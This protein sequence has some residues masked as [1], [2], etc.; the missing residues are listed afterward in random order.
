LYEENPTQYQADI[1]R[2]HRWIRGDWQ[3]GAWMLP[4]VTGNDGRLTKNTLS[5]LSRWKIFDNL[6]RSLLPLSL[7]LLLLVGWFLLPLPWLWTLTVTVT[8][9]LPVMAAAGWRLA[10]KPI[11]LTLK[12]HLTEI[13]ISVRD[14]LIRFMFGIA[15]LPYEAF[16]YTD[17]IIRTNW[18]MIVSGKKLLE[19]TPSAGASQKV[20]TDMGAVFQ[21]MWMMPLL[22]LICMVSLAYKNT[23]VLFVAAPMLILWFIAPALSWRLSRPEA[24][25]SQWLPEEQ[26]LFLHKSARKTWSFFEQFVTESENWLPPD[27]FQQQPVAIIAHR[28]SPTNLGLALLANLTAYDFGYIGGGELV[29]RCKNALESMLKLERYQGHFYNWY[30]TLTLLPLL[31][32]YVSTVDSGNLVGHLLTLRQGLLAL[33]AQPLF[34]QK[35]YEGLKTTT[36]IIQELSTGNQAEITEKILTVLEN[37]ANGRPQTDARNPEAAQPG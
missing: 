22:S 23:E 2:H 25:E 24:E 1:K 12:A 37:A 31:P 32:R 9:L 17:A 36:R 5:A 28:T 6:R 4:F 35:I 33:P 20:G 8:I 26:T 3:I 16:K 7:M 19:W 13:A 11:D 27:N 18:R 30:D 10:N 29:Q 14:T 15:V 34:T 21:S